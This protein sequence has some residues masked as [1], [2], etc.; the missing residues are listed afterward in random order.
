MKKQ[1]VK[2]TYFGYSTKTKNV[3]KLNR[4][5]EQKET[6]QIK[7]VDLGSLKNKRF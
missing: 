2:K 7:Q 3:E 6:K 5:I 1:E 4:Y